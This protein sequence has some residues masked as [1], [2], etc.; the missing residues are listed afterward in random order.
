M[1]IAETEERTEAELAGRDHSVRARIGPRPKDARH[2]RPARP[3]ALTPA[4]L[5]VIQAE[6]ARFIRS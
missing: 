4:Q 1:S 2:G 5:R 6:L 3:M